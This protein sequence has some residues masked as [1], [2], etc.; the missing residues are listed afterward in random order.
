MNISNEKKKK[1]IWIYASIECMHWSREM[2]CVSGF[3]WIQLNWLWMHHELQMKKCFLFVKIAVKISLRSWR[4]KQNIKWD[5]LALFI[6]YD[7][8]FGRMGSLLSNNRNIKIWKFNFLEWM[9][10]HTHTHN[11]NLHSAR[12]IIKC[13]TNYAH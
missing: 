10:I 7:W 8:R 11:D 2:I 9:S 4:K 1:I 3:S 13:V 12:F 6:I 5:S